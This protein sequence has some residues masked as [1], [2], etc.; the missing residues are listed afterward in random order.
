MDEIS[1]AVPIGMLYVVEC[2]TFLVSSFL[3]Y[4]A[5][6]LKTS[7]YRSCVNLSG[8]IL[9]IPRSCKDITI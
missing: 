2:Q 4:F 8:C 1:N 5:H 7:G 6:F 9:D 3:S